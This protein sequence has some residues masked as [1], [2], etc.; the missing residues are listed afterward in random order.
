M[1]RTACFI[2][3]FFR[4]SAMASDTPMN[5][6][7]AIR[8]SMSETQTV[9]TALFDLALSYNLLRNHQDRINGAMEMVAES[10]THQV[11]EIEL[12]CLSMSGSLEIRELGFHTQLEPNGVL[13]EDQVESLK[14]Q[15]NL[16]MSTLK[17][18][19]K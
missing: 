19:C 17:N 8:F 12:Y 4:L 13:L 11:A 18:I 6:A 3:L 5:C 10:C 16:T 7:Q 14:K 2:V 1:K 15:N 9:N